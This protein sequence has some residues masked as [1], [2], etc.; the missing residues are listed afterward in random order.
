MNLAALLLL[1]SGC[2]THF[3][4]RFAGRQYA[5]G[6]TGIA[7]SYGAKHNIN[8]AVAGGCKKMP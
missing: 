6:F 5:S 1:S 8:S 2:V 7:Q 3:Y 4:V